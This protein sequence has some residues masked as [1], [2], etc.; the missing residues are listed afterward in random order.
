[1]RSERDDEFLMPDT[2][3]DSDDYSDTKVDEK[4]E[5]SAAQLEMLLHMKTLYEDNTDAET[6]EI[7]WESLAFNLNVIGPAVHTQNEWFR[8]WRV[9]N[10]MERQRNGE[11]S[12]S[13]STSSKAVELEAIVINQGK[14]IENQNLILQ[15]LQRTNQLLQDIAEQKKDL[16]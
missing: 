11:Q 5:F 1:M 13:E 7:L 12:E 2:D 4:P 6:L 8:I 15:E 9:I 16:M 3:L 14:M 10:N